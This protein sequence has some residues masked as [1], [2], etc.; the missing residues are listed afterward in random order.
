[1]YLENYKALKKKIKEDINKWK[2]ILHSCVGRINTIK[3][4]M[5]PKEIYR[6]N[7]IPIKI[8][9]AYFT[10]LAQII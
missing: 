4:S 5:L 2:H 7:A 1:M 9:L 6:F 3:M 10:E 8:P